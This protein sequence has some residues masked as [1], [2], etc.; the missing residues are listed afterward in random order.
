MATLFAAII[1]VDKLRA[2]AEKNIN[3]TIHSRYGRD[4]TWFGSQ[5]FIAQPQPRYDRLSVPRMTFIVQGYLVAE[6]VVRGAGNSR[7]V[8]LVSP[9][10]KP[11][12]VALL[13]DR[14]CSR[15]S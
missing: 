5:W 12:E 6:I 3:T 10:G 4:A 15:P 8:T 14:T 13:I 11:K 9:I 7:S 1:D 2:E